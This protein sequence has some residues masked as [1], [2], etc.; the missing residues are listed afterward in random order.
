MGSAAGLRRSFSLRLLH[1]KIERQENAMDAAAARKADKEGLAR[2]A[3]LAFD[4]ALASSSTAEAS[5]RQV[6]ERPAKRMCKNSTIPL[7]SW[8]TGMIFSGSARYWCPQTL[9][10][11]T[12]YPHLS[13][14]SH[15]QRFVMHLDTGNNANTC[16][17]QQAF[18]FLGLNFAASGFG[19]CH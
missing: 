10:W 5:A 12:G 11:V 17:S 9:G 4:T 14:P 2:A 1:Q 3:S 16:I 7:P 18:E 15:T 8:T 6:L 19:R 13:D